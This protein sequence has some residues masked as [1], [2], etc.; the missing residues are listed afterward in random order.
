MDSAARHSSG[1][2]A[3]P[4]RAP[5]SKRK[6]KSRNKAEKAPPTSLID[7]QDALNIISATV[8]VAAS[9][10]SSE[11]DHSLCSNTCTTLHEYV[12]VPLLLQIEAIR[13][14]VKYSHA[15]HPVQRRGRKVRVRP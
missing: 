7:V 12:Y 4:R 6:S 15:K 8:D 11:S 10:L 2:S 1:R 3:A 13:A 14:Y 9:A 5:H